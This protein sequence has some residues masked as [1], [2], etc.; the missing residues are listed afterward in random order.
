MSNQQVKSLS[1]DNF[2]IGCHTWDHHSVTGYASKDWQIQLEK[3][4]QLLEQI[5]RKPVKYFAYPTVSGT[6]RQLHN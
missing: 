5:T 6:K 2:I 3:P 1:D 4:K